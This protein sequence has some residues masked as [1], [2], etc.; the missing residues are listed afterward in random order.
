MMPFRYWAAKNGKGTRSLASR[1]RIFLVARLMV[2]AEAGAA[3]SGGVGGRDCVA[4]IP[5]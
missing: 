3:M 1:H 2:T 4:P 5:G